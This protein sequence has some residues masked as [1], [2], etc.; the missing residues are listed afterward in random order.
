MIR[1]PVSAKWYLSKLDSHPPTKTGD[2]GSRLPDN[3]FQ[4]RG[5]QVLEKNTLSFKEI[6][7]QLKGREGGFIKISF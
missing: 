6:H 7:I 5:S 3:Y 4:R 2:R 1:P